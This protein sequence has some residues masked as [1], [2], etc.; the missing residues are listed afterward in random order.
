MITIGCVSD[1][2]GNWKDIEE[3]PEIELLI[4]AG[5]LCSTDNPKE[6]Y[7]ELK[8]NWTSF[9]NKFP[10][11]DRVI[12]V[13]GNHDYWIERNL[14]T[15]ELQRTLGFNTTILVDESMNYVSMNTGETYR[16][17][18]NPRCNLYTFAFPR[19]EGDLDIDKIPEKDI[20]ILVTHEAP[21]I[22]ELECIKISKSWYNNE[23]PGNKKLAEK[24]LKLKPL[25][26]IFGHIHYPEENNI[27]G[28][29]FINASTKLHIIKLEKS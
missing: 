6:Q 29:R 15:F 26:H 8:N 17:Y 12:L 13:P 5:D 18:G 2:H 19:L 4:V 9:I 20:D 23:C 7:L 3:T 16:I 27:S 25:V 1:I 28:I 14:G 22:D 10:G 11:L 24:V 21:R